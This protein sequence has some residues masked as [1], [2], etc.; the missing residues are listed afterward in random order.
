FEIA[1]IT[2]SDSLFLCFFLS[3]RDMGITLIVIPRRNLVSP[4]DLTRDAPILNVFEPL[5]VGRGPV[6]GVEPDK[7]IG[8]GSESALGEAIHFDKP[9]VGQHRL[10]DDAGATRARYTQLV[11]F[12]RD[13]Q[14]LCLQ[15]SNHAL[16]RFKTIKAAIGLG[17]EIVWGGT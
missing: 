8:D 9:L 4:P 2:F 11:R 7:T 1:L 16:A 3:A 6:L 12:F 5:V 13:Q 14:T 10:D 15:V 17:N